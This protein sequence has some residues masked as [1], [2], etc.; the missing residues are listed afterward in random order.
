MAAVVDTVAAAPGRAGILDVNAGQACNTANTGGDGDLF[1]NTNLNTF[2]L[3]YNA[4]GGS[5]TV[6]FNYGPAGTIDGKTLAAKTAVILT[7]KTAIFGPFPALYNN[8]AG[9]VLVTYSPT[10]TGCFIQP[11][12]SA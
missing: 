7:T 11:F 10:P 1:D 2:V 4:L 6:T 5:L 9:Q 12:K 8:A 3:I